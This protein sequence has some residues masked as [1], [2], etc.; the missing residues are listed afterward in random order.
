MSSL[1]TTFTT[2]TS[3]SQGYLAT[4]GNAART[5]LGALLA[6]KPYQELAAKDAGT[7]IKAARTTAKFSARQ[8]A[9]DIAALYAEANRYE[10]SMPN[11]SAEL[12]F[13]AARG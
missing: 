7:A 10:S 1:T 8:H 12:R 5:L 4:V 2:A 11:L 9:R 6:V 3:P 13:M